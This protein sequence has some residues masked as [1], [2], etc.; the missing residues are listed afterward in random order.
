MEPIANSVK[1]F[2]TV[3][4]KQTQLLYMLNVKQ[5]AEQYQLVPCLY[6]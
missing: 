1:T 3:E 2:V 6:S 4:K 5:G